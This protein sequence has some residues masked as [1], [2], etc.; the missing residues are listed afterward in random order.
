M[1]NAKIGNIMWICET[2]EK[3]VG[4]INRWMGLQRSLNIVHLFPSTPH[5]FCCVQIVLKTSIHFP[6]N[7]T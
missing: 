5:T 7:A 2:L 6:Q 1:D 4:A 3:D